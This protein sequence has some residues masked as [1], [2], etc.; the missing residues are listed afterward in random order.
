M[1]DSKMIVLRSLY[2]RMKMSEP[3][4]DSH[5]LYFL[6]ELTRSFKDDERDRN[7]I[8]SKREK[9][10]KKRQPNFSLEDDGISRLNE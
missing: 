6:F 7:E 2:I 1:G 3:I 10:E 9:K 5:F 4:D 8:K